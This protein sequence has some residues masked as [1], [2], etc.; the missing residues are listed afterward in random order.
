MVNKKLFSSAPRGQTA[1]PTDTINLAGGRAYKMDDKHALAQ[2]AATGCFSDTFYLSADMQLQNV[3]KLC[4]KV[5]PLFVA[6]A[7][8]YARVYGYMKDMP[9]FMCAYL[10]KHDVETL[11]KVF[12][13]VIDSPKM[14]RNFVQVIRSGVVGRKSL[15]AAPKKLVQ[16]W[17]QTRK[18]E[19]LFRGSVG[20]DPSVAD[21]IKM[22]HP[23][24][25]DKSREAL[26]GYLIGKN[27]N[28]KL[29][30]KLVQD[31]EA[32]KKDPERVEM[33]PVPFQMVT[34]LPL[35]KSAWKNIA[36]R[37]S[38]TE[39]RMNLNTLE[40][41]DVFKDKTMVKLV[42]DK[43]RNAE[44]IERS[45][46]FPYQIMTSYMYYEGEHLIKEAL[47]DA[48]RDIRRQITIQQGS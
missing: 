34:A 44:A 31:Y 47:Q 45:R 35:S 18:P 27:N 32:F 48:M 1:P 28:P 20:N 23:L 39:L 25:A 41:H 29:L 9:A 37:M 7:A 16:N 38:W 26:Y 11:K 12:P 30:P 4:D 10:A 22:V 3:L 13:F 46:V 40:R 19:A 14:L 15:G 24:P 36:A 42:A 2:A 43:L 17:I 21:L 6:K 33:P 8:V 5:E